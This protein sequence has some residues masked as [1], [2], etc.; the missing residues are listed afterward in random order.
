L[1]A[2]AVLG[3]LVLPFI[4]RA[5]AVN[6]LGKLLD[7]P[8]TIQAVRINPFVLSGTIRGL[9][10]E[11][12][13]GERFVAWQEVYVNLQ[14]SSFLGKAWV[15]KEVRV[16]DPFARVQLNKDRSLNFSDLLQKLS[17]MIGTNPPATPS[18]PLALRVDSF[19]IVG[20]VATYADLTPNTP[21]RYK[22][23][24]VELMLKQFHTD[25]ENKN[26]Y[27]FTGVTESGEKFSWSGLFLL[28]PLRSRGELAVE[29]VSLRPY[30][31]IYQ[32]F[33]KFEIRDGIADVRATYDFAWDGT[34]GVAMVTN[35]SVRLRG[36]KVAEKNQP[37][38][39]AEVAELA[40]TGA[41]ADAVARRAEV[42][43]V[44][45]HKGQLMVQR[46]SDAKL[47]LIEMARPDGTNISGSVIWMLQSVTNLFSQFL[48][49][50]NAGHGV[51]RRLEVKDSSLV[52]EDDT[53]PRPVRLKLT[54][55][56]VAATNLSNLAGSN[57][58]ASATM[59]WN[60]N[61]TV[62]VDVVASVNPLSA[63]VQ[64]ALNQLELSPLG[65]YLDPFAK[66]FIVGSL[67]NMDG[68]L[69]VRGTA[70]QLPEATF[71]G[72][73]KVTDFASKDGET[74]EELVKFGGVDLSGITARLNPPEFAVRE[75]AL[76]DFSAQIILETNGALNVLRVA[77][78]LDTNPPASSISEGANTKTAD[79]KSLA[80]MRKQFGSMLKLFSSTNLVSASL[81]VKAS[82][83][84]VLFT[85]MDV[86][87]TDRTVSP[88]M[89]ASLQEIR[90]Q[91]RGVSSDL[92][93]E[94]VANLHARVGQSG[95]V[96][97]NALLPPAGPSVTNTLKVVIKN[98]D[99][100]PAGPYAGKFLGYNL[101]KGKLNLE[102]HYQMTARKLKAQNLVMLDQF[103]LGEKVASDSATKL[104]VKLAVALLKDRNGRI[105]L[106]LPIE[107]DLDD[108]KFRLG[109]IIL[110][111]L[112]TVI[113]K[114][115]T[116]PFA[117]LGSLF[118][119]KGEDVRFQEFAPG[120]AELSQASIEKLDAVLVALY[121]RPGLELEVEGSVDP[122]ADRDALQRQKLEKEFKF[123]KW[124]TFRKREQ[125]RLSPEQVTLTPDEY[126]TFLREAYARRLAAVATSATA[127]KGRA[128]ITVRTDLKG[129]EQMMLQP[130]TQAPQPDI[131]RELLGTIEITSEDYRALALARA[132]IVKDYVLKSGR[133]ESER[134]FQAEF[135]AQGAA[136]N[137]SRVYLHL[138]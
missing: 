67:L 118:P 96:E 71:Q 52:L 16:T 26:P 37:A 94:I 66:V 109:P 35:A 79:K 131:E 120:R 135:P 51:L 61:G 86:L 99:L 104:P 38:S 134:V 20:A 115:V 49:T 92:S 60:T 15:F 58:T 30:A 39:I 17:S 6:Q 43:S 85:N 74:G 22:L 103:T 108:P 64:I 119:G 70:D 113:T 4:V 14:L 123:R 48:T 111:A 8:V 21:F 95:P 62:R 105:E 3:F 41:S 31:P 136:T 32:D 117:A 78:M 13:D 9:L 133:V 83:A 12:R 126:A 68:Q 124:T 7:R 77:R 25:P 84:S 130:T 112:G 116:S 10:I 125:E 55:I 87:V 90:G 40:V 76:R 28:S 42:D 34:L 72:N 132:N 107:G 98:A 114:L 18:K 44:T 50:T 88:V 1:A 81:P 106:E 97:I 33:V 5:V 102:V 29:Q 23:G 138:R 80:D 93:S 121:E 128:T 82:V 46:S 69:K 27:S 24:P 129:A 47:N 65:P 89:H 91:V 110:H 100:N 53:N 56:T 54:D 137:G 11:D 101:R 19:Q 45:I 36:F 59:N 63:D 127:A 75:L 73:V 2:Y 122:S 57:L